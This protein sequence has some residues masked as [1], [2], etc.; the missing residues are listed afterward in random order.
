MATPKPLYMKE[1]VME[2]KSE[3]KETVELWIDVK[4]FISSN[5]TK[6]MIMWTHR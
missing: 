4:K 1:S 5:F 6:H 3:W 2:E